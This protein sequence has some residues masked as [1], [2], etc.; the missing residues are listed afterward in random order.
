M[1]L[2]NLLQLICVASWLPAA[3]LAG[4]VAK[5]KDLSATC[6]Q[7]H[8]V[9]GNSTIA[10]NPKLA[11]QYESYLIQALSAYR[12]GK[13]TS[14]IMQPFAAPLSDQ[15]IKDLAAYFSSQESQLFVTK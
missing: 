7:C 15:D 2:K 3:A 9:D 13:R 5:G 8:G 12:S 6:A 4:D 11:G 10:S 1:K 14:A